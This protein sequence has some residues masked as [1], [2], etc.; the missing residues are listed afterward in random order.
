ML[1]ALFGYL[2]YLP[3]LKIDFFSWGNSKND[4]LYLLVVPMILLPL[5]IV[6]SIIKYLILRKID[7]TFL[8]R[9]S[10]ILTIVVVLLDTFILLV[11]GSNGG[12][13]TVTLVT[14]TLT[15]FLLVEMILFKKPT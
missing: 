12:L 5:I 8:F 10:F 13:M 4:G 7:T 15:I 11:S 2:A 9:N 6:F 1:I 3:T 14:I